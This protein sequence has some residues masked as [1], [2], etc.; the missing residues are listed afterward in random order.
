MM[1]KFRIY[2][3]WVYL[4]KVLHIR[5]HHIDYHLL[6]SDSSFEVVSE[7]I[8]EKLLTLNIFKYM[9]NKKIVCLKVLEDG[10]VDFKTPSFR[11]PVKY[12]ESIL[13]LDNVEYVSNVNTDIIY[14]MYKGEK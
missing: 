2:D 5:T 3:K 7:T 4:D 11:L 13:F 6:D 9:V 12:G 1:P 8:K 14:L 10:Y